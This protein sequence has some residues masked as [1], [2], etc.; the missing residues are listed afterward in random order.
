MRGFQNHALFSNHGKHLKKTL[1]N[2]SVTS[3]NLEIFRLV[4]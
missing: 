3:I 4:I 2:D 1:F